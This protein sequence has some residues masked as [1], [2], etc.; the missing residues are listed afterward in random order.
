M[1]RRYPVL[2]IVSGIFA[3][4]ETKTYDVL[5]PFFLLLGVGAAITLMKLLGRFNYENTSH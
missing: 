3:Y 2:L 5:T 1:D 4:F